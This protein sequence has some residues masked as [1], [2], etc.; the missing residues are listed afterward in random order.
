MQT[1]QPGLPPP[2]GAT[3]GHPTPCHGLNGPDPHL[4]LSPRLRLPVAPS[5]A[6]MASAPPPQV[7]AP[8]AGSARLS[9]PS[10]PAADRCRAVIG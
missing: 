3:P 8:A 7:T 1:T 9:F 5:P 6:L 2:R 4:G 10:T